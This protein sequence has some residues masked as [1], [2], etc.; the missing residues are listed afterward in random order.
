MNE[1][2]SQGH[3]YLGA[4]FAVA[5]GVHFPAGLRGRGATG[6]SNRHTPALPYVLPT[7]AGN[8]H[9]DGRALPHNIAY[10]GSNARIVH[11][12]PGAL[13]YAWPIGDSVSH[14]NARALTH[15]SNATDAIITNSYPD[16]FANGGSDA[17]T[18]HRNARIANSHPD[19]IADGGSYA[20]AHAV[21]P[22]T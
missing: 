20:R 14:D 19:A 10:T 13:T 3:Y 2:V 22:A 12:Y 1:R 18:S 21:S 9:R 17:R 11:T 7:G 4:F 16:S 15:A 8:T 5:G 6:D